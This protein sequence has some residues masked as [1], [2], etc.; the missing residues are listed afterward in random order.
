MATDEEPPDDLR[1]RLTWPQ[2]A[3]N[4]EGPFDHAREDDE[5]HPPIASAN[6]HTPAVGSPVI[7][8]GPRPPVGRTLPQSVLPLPDDDG[9]SRRS[10]GRWAVGRRAAAQRAAEARAQAARAAA[11][12]AAAERAAAQLAAVRRADAQRAAA[13]RAT[14][15]RA[16]TQQAEA[17]AAAQQKAAQ[18][19]AQAAAQQKAAQAEAQAAAQ[20]K[21]AQAEAQAAQQ[22]AAQAEAQAAAQQK[23]AQQA[24]AQAAQQKAA[25]QAEAADRP[26]GPAADAPRPDP[27]RG[28]NLAPATEKRDSQR[29]AELRAAERE[30]ARVASE[31][32]DAQRLAERADAQRAAAQRAGTERVAAEAAA[33]RAQAEAAAQ[34]AATERAMAEKADAERAAAQAAV[35]RAAAERAAERAAAEAETQR[36]A[37][38][39]AVAAADAQSRRRPIVTV[40]AEAVDDDDDDQPATPRPTVTTQEL[41]LA[42]RSDSLQA[43]LASIALRI[44]ALTS[45]T[46]TFRNLISDRITDYAE[47]VG[48]LGASAAGDLDD[49]RHLHERAIEQIRRSV[50]DAEDNVRRLSRSVGD[51][52]AKVGALVAAVRESGDAIDQI[53]SDRDQVSDTLVRSL[54]RVEDALTELTEG[55]I[56]SSFARLGDMINAL[57][58]ERDRQ[59]AVWN[60]FEH[61]VVA[62]ADEREHAADVLSRLERSVGEM[63]VGRE[64]G[65]AKVLARLEARVDEIG[66]SMTG[67]SG[68][69]IATT[70]SRVDARLKEMSTDLVVGRDRETARALSQLSA[71]VDGIAGLVAE[72]RTDLAPIENRLNRLT[73]TAPQVAPLDLAGL[74][75]RLDELADVVSQGSAPRPSA[76]GASADR[77]E[78]L[79]R[80]DQL[81]QQLG[82]QLEA[83]RRRIALRAR[84]GGPA[85]DEATIAAIADAVV[86][87]L[88]ET[89]ARPVPALSR[90]LPAR[91]ADA[92]AESPGRGREQWRT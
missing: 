48:R 13:E 79:E 7:S 23:A 84:G 60:Q 62:L 55:R 45:T 17:Q 88:H 5:P 30:A 34:R 85:M 54:E 11:D 75:A 26:D 68:D 1:V 15:E 73:R 70:L 24:E 31:R 16:A 71:Q 87:R 43:A 33:K 82:E 29:I 18:A 49:Y 2:P 38:E 41:I 4:D 6:D 72:G 86:A 22:K 56:A 27:G 46:S 32:V 57:A 21:A 40:D 28:D 89:Q 36:A 58:G 3:V 92:T 83:L 47:Q 52:D 35:E 14:A 9:A 20:Q 50:S 74:Y 69:E 10:G 53:I 64:R 59:G 39:R 8:G 25:Q 81:G 76:P 51:L 90:P 77:G 44:D 91:R 67:I 63:T 19:E 12:R 80:F 37:A 61:A 42:G 65:L 78:I 66:A